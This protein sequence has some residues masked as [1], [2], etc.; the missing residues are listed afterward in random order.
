MHVQRPSSILLIIIIMI[1]IVIIF[2]L[3]Y[4]LPFKGLE[5]IVKL[6]KK[7]I[8]SLI[9]TVLSIIQIVVSINQNIIIC[10]YYFFTSP[11]KTRDTNINCR[12]FQGWKC[13][14][15]VVFLFQNH[16]FNIQCQNSVYSKMTRLQSS[17]RLQPWTH[18]TATK[19]YHHR[20]PL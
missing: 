17:A 19:I 2:I 8:C 14:F 3:F 15:K 6:Y 1:N 18:R 13:L 4:R 5:N 20:L 9:N 7:Y 16:I 11:S 10:I 12:H